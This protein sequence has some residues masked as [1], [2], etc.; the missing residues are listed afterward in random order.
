MIN[1]NLCPKNVFYAKQGVFRNDRK[2]I[3]IE[4]A[5]IEDAIGRCPTN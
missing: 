3:Y 2:R 1:L 4:I 5:V